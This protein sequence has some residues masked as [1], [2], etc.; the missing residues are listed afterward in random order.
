SD[1]GLAWKMQLANT[2]PGLNQVRFVDQ[3]TGYLLGDG[4]DRFPTGM[5]RTTDSG[6]NWEPVAGP[7]TT[8]WLAADFLD[9][10]TGIFGGAWSRFAT[11]R[12]NKLTNS[13]QADHADSLSG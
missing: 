10:K 2:L 11:L 12:D 7:R 3:K 6:Q 1:G 8:S 4:C 13:R 5:F 9:G